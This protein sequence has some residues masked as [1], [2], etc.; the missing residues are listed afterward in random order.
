M[1]WDAI[2]K[3][4]PEFTYEMWRERSASLLA[5]A[6]KYNMWRG[7]AK[8]RLLMDVAPRIGILS[9]QFYMGCGFHYALEQE[10]GK[11]IGNL[12]IPVQWCANHCAKIP[13]QQLK[14]MWNQISVA[15]LIKRVG[16]A[17]KSVSKAAA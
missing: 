5:E 6:E 13:E 16:K 9:T 2:D 1:T 4:L 15:D 12:S 8:L 14:M 11:L 3:S 10:L 7:R 17:E